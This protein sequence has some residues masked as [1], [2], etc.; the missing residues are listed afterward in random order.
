MLVKTSALLALLFP[1]I[2]LVGS[3]GATAAEEP[4]L[5]NVP[6]Q[7]Y[8][9]ASMLRT[10][11]TWVER[12]KFPAVDVHNHLRRAD[13]PEK[14]D[15]VIRAMNDTNVLA[16]VNLDGGWGETLDQNIERMN[17][18][19]PGRFIQYMRID[20]SRIDEPGFGQAMAPRRSRAS[21]ASK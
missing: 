5:K 8:E 14:I 9:P 1:L 15:E 2:S 10:G 20:W 11:E 21:R 7:D 18:R 19:Y 17:G 16:V 12:A 13:T 4:D 3:T 6:I